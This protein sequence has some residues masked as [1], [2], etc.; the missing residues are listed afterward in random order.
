MRDLHGNRHDQADCA[1]IIHI[2]LL[3]ILMAAFAFFVSGLI[4]YDVISSLV[5]LFLHIF[6]DYPC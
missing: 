4:R 2:V 6:G 3:M 1:N 5:L